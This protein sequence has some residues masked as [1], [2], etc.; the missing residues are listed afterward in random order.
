MLEFE[1]AAD[2]IRLGAE[3]AERMMPEI[4]AGIQLF[5]PPSQRP[6]YKPPD[7]MPSQTDDFF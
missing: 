7:D 2:L 4:Q 1:K 3:A 6:G 5:L